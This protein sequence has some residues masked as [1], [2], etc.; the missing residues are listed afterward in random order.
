MVFF[1]EN[2]LLYVIMAGIIYVPIFFAYLH[3]HK[4]ELNQTIIIDN[5]VIM[6]ENFIVKGKIVNATIEYNHIESI[7][8]KREIIRPFCRCIYVS[9]MNDHPLIIN[10]D[11]VNF[12]KLWSLICENAQKAN[13]EII[14]DKKVNDYFRAQTK[15]T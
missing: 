7:K 4:A 11:Y 10:S 2:I 3:L 14:I 5:N 6:C 1:K 9:L 15:D 13:P 12:F 8:I